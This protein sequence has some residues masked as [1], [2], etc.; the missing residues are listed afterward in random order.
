MVEYNN[1]RIENEPTS[2]YL[3]TLGAFCELSAD[4]TE[5]GNALRGFDFPESRRND[6]FSTNHE[7]NYFSTFDRDNDAYVS[8]NCA[9]EDGSGWW[10]NRCSSGKFNFLLTSPHELDSKFKR[11]V[12]NQEPN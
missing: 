1:F 11:P 2:Y 4:G 9:C 3:A 8:G 10:F 6:I 5:M 12:C 7:R